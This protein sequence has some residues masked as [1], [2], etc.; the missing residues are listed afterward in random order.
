LPTNLCC[1]ATSCPA[2]LGWH[3]SPGC[4]LPS[5]QRRHVTDPQPWQQ[6][7]PPLQAME[8]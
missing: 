5:L 3:F 4:R 8:R 2:L 6:M 7:V 1:P